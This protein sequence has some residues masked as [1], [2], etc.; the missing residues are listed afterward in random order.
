MNLFKY[1]VAFY[2]CTKNDLSS[3]IFT[4][5]KNNLKENIKKLLQICRIRNKNVYVLMGSNEMHPGLKNINL[6]VFK[7]EIFFIHS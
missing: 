4:N 6:R 3:L 1:M 2:V 5:I 7:I